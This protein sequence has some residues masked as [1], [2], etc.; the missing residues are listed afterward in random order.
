MQPHHRQLTGEDV[1]VKER[2][3]NR[4]RLSGDNCLEDKMED[5]QT[6]CAHLYE[7]FLQVN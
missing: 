5:F 2:R 7:R 6:L 4:Q 3:K 1:Q